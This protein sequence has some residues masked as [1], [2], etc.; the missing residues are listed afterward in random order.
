[1]VLAGHG[2]VA[3]A[4][5]L[6]GEDQDPSYIARGLE[7]PETYPFRQ[8]VMNGL[9]AFDLLMQREEV[10]PQRIAVSGA[11]QGGGL[12]LILAALRPEIAAVTADV[13]MLCDFRTSIRQAGWP[14][15]EI[16]RY[17]QNNPASENQVWRTL[18]YYDVLNF[19]PR[20]KTPTL[21]SLG[22]KDTICL[23][24]TIFAVYNYLPGEKEI[25]VY[26]EAGH[27]GGGPAQ[28]MYKLR[29]LDSILRPFDILQP[30][31][32]IQ[33]ET[34]VEPTAPQIP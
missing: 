7:A 25:K 29:W 4:V 32:D 14:Y 9:R 8:I 2:Y 6:V 17:L 24:E 15:N 22:L 30:K 12:A 23:P 27:E 34:P 11:S 13:P 28:W 20:I 5:E 16:A 21:M 1:L 18:S 31:E 33:Q 3:L 19:A 10:D 26:P